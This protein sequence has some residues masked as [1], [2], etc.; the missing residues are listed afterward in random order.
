[1]LRVYGFLADRDHIAAQKALTTIH[2]GIDFLKEFPFTCRKVT[3]DN[4]FLREMII[5]FGH[6]GYVLMF[7]IE[8]GHTVTILA[9]R[10]QREEDY[11]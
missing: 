6:N 5:S 7:E 8:D 11:H 10:H 2:K 4:P 1:M 3:A 9:V